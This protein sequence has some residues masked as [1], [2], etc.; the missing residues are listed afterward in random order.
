[1]ADKFK[2]LGG[3]EKAL[4]S[5][6]AYQ[7]EYLRETIKLSETTFRDI[8]KEFFSPIT[9]TYK[10]SLH[11]ESEYRGI[12]PASLPAWGTI[13]TYKLPSENGA[14]LSDLVLHLTF[15]AVG[16]ENP[17]LTGGVRELLDRYRYTDFPGIRCI[18]YVDF[19]VDG[20]PFERVYNDRWLQY[21]AT[22]LSESERVGFD[23][24]CG[25]EQLLDADLFNTDYHFMEKRKITFGAQTERYYQDRVVMVLPM[26]LSFTENDTAIPCD[27][28]RGGAEL[29]IKL[30]SPGQKLLARVSP[31]VG[32]TYQDPSIGT[33]M[34]YAN[35]IHMEPDVYDK[36]ITTNPFMMIK[37]HK[38]VR[39]EINKPTAT[40]PLTDLRSPMDHLYF[41]FLPLDQKDHFDYWWQLSNM[42]TVP[43][44]YPKLVISTLTPAVT[45]SVDPTQT[46]IVRQSNPMVNKI[47]FNIT[48]VQRP[49]YPKLPPKFYESYLPSLKNSMY[50]DGHG[51]MMMGMP[52]LTTSAN[53]IEGMY[54][55]DSDRALEL[56]YESSTITVD[57]PA[58]LIII[59]RVI[60]FIVLDTRRGA[61][62]LYSV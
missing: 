24:A 15:E 6:Y 27:V 16:D 20:V 28:F 56:E 48:G 30:V 21:R 32:V 36:L 42:T 44:V 18:E 29:R 58:E 4:V 3:G 43:I 47:G 2:I 7:E 22:E 45:Y 23:R 57:T 60:N 25:Q 33:A 49:I 55:F 19:V 51:W 37:Q 34:L 31:T 50:P 52:K 53:T 14:I 8:T 35:Y 61:Y 10:P 9:C 40:I 12:A 11:T 26:K 46:L 17:T 39:K 62:A 38:C 54:Y 5:K 59:A 41:G 13:L 1:M